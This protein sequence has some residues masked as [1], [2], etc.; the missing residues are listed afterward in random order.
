MVVQKCTFHIKI[1][2]LKNH[3]FRVLCEFTHIDCKSPVQNLPQKPQPLRLQDIIS[4]I[5]SVNRKP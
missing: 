2:M 4:S 5:E 1:D 3:C